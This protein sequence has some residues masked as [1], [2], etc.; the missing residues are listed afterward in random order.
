M[1]RR[2]RVRGALAAVA[3]MCAVAVLPGQAYAAGEPGAY[4]FDPDAETVTGQEVSADAVALRP[5]T[6]YRSAISGNQKLYYRL[7]LDA[8][9]NAYV[10][11]VVVPKAGGEVAYGDGVT[12]SIRDSSDDECSSQDALFGS[13]QYPRPIAAYASRRIEADGSCQEAGTYH[14]LVER[15]SKAASD[16]GEWELELRY[17]SEPALANPSSRPTEAPTSW[18]SASPPPPVA[19]T[20]N[21]RRGG[22]GHYDATS[23]ETGE[24]KDRIEPGQTL[25]YRVPVDWGQQ[26]YATAGLSNSTSAKNPFV[27]SA[28]AMSLENPA[29]GHVTEVSPMAYAGKPT[30]VSFDPLPPV[31]YENRYD[32]SDETNGMRFAGWYYLSVS[33]SPR[34]AAAYGDKPITL[35]LQISVEGK[36][37]E[38]PYKGDAGIFAVTQGDKEAARKGQSGAQAAAGADSGTMK[39]VAAAGIGTGTLLV[40]W[41]GVWTLV[42]RRR[43]AAVPAAP[44]NAGAY[45]YGGPP[46]AW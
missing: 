4:T 38:A 39:V 19:A 20:D 21:T 40:L 18:P 7:N 32:S 41:L 3:A 1:R 15:Q 12:I 6:V 30:S 2:S 31:A 34:V 29:L 43:A 22:A 27:G 10:S 24:W 16:Q 13:A 17:V 23:L 5:D 37:D 8:K 9:T 36:A 35:T 45:P 26:L 42:A 33:L 28:L 25:F 44:A 46:Q 11:A 14:V